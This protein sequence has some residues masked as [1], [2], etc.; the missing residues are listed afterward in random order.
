MGLI[1]EYKM[2]ILPVNYHNVYMVGGNNGVLGYCTL[3][4]I[5]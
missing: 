1:S 3:W 4:T 5:R 2:L